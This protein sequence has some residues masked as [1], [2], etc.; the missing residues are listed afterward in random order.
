MSNFTTLLVVSPLPDGKHWRIV[1]P[2]VYAVGHKDSPDRIEVPAGFVTDFASSPPAVWSIIPPWGRYGK[3]AV[4][5]DYLYQSIYWMLEQPQYRALFVHHYYALNNPRKF[6]DD[7]FRE[8]MIVLGVKPWRVS[9]MYWGVRVL[10][11]LAWPR[12]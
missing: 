3:A 2:F 7:I 10:G 12:K 1:L 11:W 6:A 9:L 8:A 4:L 5:H